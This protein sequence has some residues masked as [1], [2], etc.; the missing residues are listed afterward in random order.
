MSPT[1]TIRVDIPSLGTQPPND[2]TGRI[3]DRAKRARSEYYEALKSKTGLTADMWSAVL[4]EALALAASA[5]RTGSPEIRR[6]A[7][8]VLAMLTEDHLEDPGDIEGL[9]RVLTDIGK[10]L[11]GH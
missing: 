1:V 4:E 11:R 9:M 3:D 2:T 7:E 6:C 5:H 8:T 10:Y